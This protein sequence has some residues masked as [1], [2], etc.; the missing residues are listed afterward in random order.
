MAN[1]GYWTPAI[2]LTKTNTNAMMVQTGTDASKGDAGLEGR[3]FFTTDDGKIYRD[4]GSAWVEVVTRD[5]ATTVPSVR[6]LGTGSTQ[7]AVGNHAGT[8]T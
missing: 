1:Q 3:L 4:S 7:A 2:Q 6:T 8:L 5:G